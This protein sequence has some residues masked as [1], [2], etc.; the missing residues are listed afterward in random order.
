M[1]EIIAVQKT[2]VAENQ[3]SKPQTAQFVFIPKFDNEDVY[4]SDINLQLDVRF[5]EYGSIEI[6]AGDIPLFVQHERGAFRQY[7][8]YPINVANTILRQSK[9]LEVYVWNAY[10]PD[11]VTVTVSFAYSLDPLTG[12]AI[13]APRSQTELNNEL[14]VPV[15]GLD[16]GT[17][18][19]ISKLQE[20]RAVIGTQPLELDLDAISEKISLLLSDIETGGNLQAI[21]QGVFQIFELAGGQ[22]IAGDTSGIAAQL[23][24]LLDTIQ[25]RDLEI[26]TTP[27]ELLLK[28]LTSKTIPD[29]LGISDALQATVQEAPPAPINT[30]LVK[31][32]TGIVDLLNGFDLHELQKMIVLLN[33]NIP[34]LEA[35]NAD[36]SIINIFR[37]L[38]LRLQRQH[39]TIPSLKESE[40]NTLFPKILYA[41]DTEHTNIIDSK[42]HTNF[43]ASMTSDELKQVWKYT[44]DDAPV[45]VPPSME[46][47]FAYTENS[48]TKTFIVDLGDSFIEKLIRITHSLNGGQFF[49][50]TGDAGVARIAVYASNEK[51]V[52]IDPANL[53]QTS[54]EH[55]RYVSPGTWIQFG[56]V[57]FK[58]NKRYIAIVTSLE[59]ITRN[60][61]TLQYSID[62]IT[63]LSRTGGIA[64]LSFELKDNFDVWHPVITAQELGLITNGGPPVIVRFNETDFGFPL[65]AS[66]TLF[67]AKLS[68]TGGSIKTGVS[69]TLLS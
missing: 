29:D 56:N 19:L 8:T 21:Q 6:R 24:G 43:I 34:A 52:P 59:N 65:P 61:A 42:G 37:L 49:G 53:I 46:T 15:D 26:K 45:S 30:I 44:S 20:I 39:E 13:G 33:I 7:Q 31:L 14:T 18:E 1:T 12:G 17:K 68:I 35:E 57:H 66:T 36:D 54:G 9:K 40:N 58:T 47:R 41:K 50:G 69:M 11:P 51:A 25:N 10:S 64:A 38:R 67:R 63:D 32:R 16:P 62:T 2:I 28:Q 5:S 3:K 55:A 48:A 27:L 60:T 4:I 22:D 23:Q